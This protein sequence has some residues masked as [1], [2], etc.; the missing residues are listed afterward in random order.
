MP[1]IR[2]AINQN[3]RNHEVKQEQLNIESTALHFK[4]FINLFSHQI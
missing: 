4:Y 3:P 2:P 1:G